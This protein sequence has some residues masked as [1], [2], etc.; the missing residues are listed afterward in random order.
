MEK[1]V[2]IKNKETGEVIRV[3]KSYASKKVELNKDWHYTSKGAYKHYL[4]TL[5]EKFNP[6]ILNSAIKSKNTKAQPF[7][8][9]NRKITPGRKVYYQDLN[10]R[11][12]IRTGKKKH[13]IIRLFKT[14][15][16][17]LGF[18]KHSSMEVHVR[19]EP[20]LGTR[21]SSKYGK[22]NIED[23]VITMSKDSIIKLGTKTIKHWINGDSLKKMKEDGKSKKQKFKRKT[24]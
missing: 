6:G 22:A 4:N 5:T 7:S 15:K 2:C 24:N 17:D 13:S 3:N 16:S 8:G 1:Q 20:I 11:K 21:I 19:V 12:I 23:E 9:N 18:I 10:I 14:I